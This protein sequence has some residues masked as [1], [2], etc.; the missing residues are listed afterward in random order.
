VVL[1]PDLVQPI[2]ERVEEVLVR[3]DDGAVQCEFDH[4]KRAT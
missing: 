3:S 4:G 1:A 2:A